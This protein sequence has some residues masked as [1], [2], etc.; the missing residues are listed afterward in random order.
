MHVIESEWRLWK[1]VNRQLLTFASWRNFRAHSFLK[2]QLETGRTHQIRVHMAHR[3]YPLVG[4]PVYSG[5]L[6]IPAGISNEL[7]EELRKFPRQALHAARLSLK[8]PASGEIHDWQSPLPDD[9]QKLL[10]ILQADAS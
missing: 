10:Q 6:R 2:L 8:H 7:A 1:A 4:D 9:M 3:Q 5:R